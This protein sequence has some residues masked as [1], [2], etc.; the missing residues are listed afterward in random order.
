MPTDQDQEFIRFAVAGGHLTQEQADRAIQA[1]ADIEELG[2]T[3]SAPDMLLRQGLLDERA[4]GLVRQ[5]IAVSKT[6]MRVPRELGGFELCER[7]GQGGMGSVFRARQKDLGRDV[8]VKLLAPR[9]SQNARFV[10]RFMREARAAGRLSHPNIVAAIDVGESEGFHYFAMEFVAGESLG[11][12]IA[13]DGPLP[14]AR[15]LAITSEVAQALDHAHERGLIHRDIKPD[16]I[17]IDHDGRSRVADFGLAKAVGSEAEPGGGNFVG[18]PAYVAPEQVR[19][20]PD[21][22]CRA[23]IFSLGVVLFE[24]LTGQRPFTGSNPV[25]VAAAVV[26][27]PLPSVR[28]IRRDVPLAVARLL[29]RMTAKNRADRFATPAD[30][31]RA[32]D[33]ATKA[34]RPAARPPALG[35][36]PGAAPAQQ[37]RRVTQRRRQS[38]TGAYVF[39]FLAIGGLLALLVYLAGPGRKSKTSSR[40]AVSVNA[41]QRE[42]PPDTTGKMV[43]NTAKRLLAQLNSENRKAKAFAASNPSAYVSQMQRYQRI[44]E[45]FPPATRRS[46]D[47]EGLAVVKQAENELARLEAAAAKAASEELARRSTKADALM[48]DGNLAAALRL[49]ETFPTELRTAQGMRE[50]QTLRGK[51][52]TRAAEAFDVL[53]E[54][55]R[56]LVRE[57]ELEKARA[58]YAS[59][60]G[61]GITTIETRVTRAIQQID[62]LV[63]RQEKVDVAKARAAYPV[64]AKAA[65]AQIAAHEYDAARKALDAAV[66]DPHLLPIQGK[67]RGLQT[68]V[69]SAGHAWTRIEAAAR[70]LTRGEEI[71]VGGV[72]GTFDRFEDGRLYIR[73]GEVVLARALSELRPREMVTL[74]GEE[75]DYQFRIDFGLFLLAE[76]EYAASRAV[77]ETAAKK[78]IDIA[79]ARDLLDRLS[80]RP[81]PTCHGDKTVDCKACNGTGDAGRTV[82]T[83]PRCNGRGGGRCAACRGSGI[84]R[85]GRCGGTGRLTGGFVCLDC[86][87]GGRLKC[88]RCGGD[89]RV[90][91]STCKG[92]GSLVSTTPCATCRGKKRVPC[93]KCDGKGALPPLETAVVGT[94]GGG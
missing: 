14:L 63:R 82:K 42:P 28:K 1:L 38:H 61:I 41:E 92:R 48:E 20:D 16:N 37:P 11:K 5:S 87:G 46:L 80:P 12:L 6:S 62:D 29:D 75:A 68:L 50:L 73:S 32:L 40:E 36:A 3:A 34:P 7:I 58:L 17:L 65:L 2:G 70:K 71:R 74:V 27:E 4:I 45:N 47:S 49:F 53:D 26:S 19:S 66:V 94:G 81:C 60:R 23:D 9:L 64:L 35:G 44:L 13:R 91:C 85:C 88:G 52:R 39:A 24:M 69:R 22:D 30:L 89:G 93:P 83:C 55:G 43:D 90:R 79:E 78:G 57:N 84:V 18:T 67:L 51:Y 31:L 33:S 86:G 77:I 8:A 72:A 21:I 15:A 10:Q 59:V 54:K 56:E 25:A 76:K